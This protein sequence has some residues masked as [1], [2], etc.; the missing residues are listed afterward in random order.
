MVIVIVQIPAV[1]K[2]KFRSV[3]CDPIYDIKEPLGDCT[4]QLTLVIT[5]PTIPATYGISESYSK[6][7]LSPEHI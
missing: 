4:I 7:T 3:P 2:I 6:V 1:S 5:C